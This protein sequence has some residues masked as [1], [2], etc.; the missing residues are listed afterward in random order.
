MAVIEHAPWQRPRPTLAWTAAGVVLVAVVALYLALWGTRYGL[1]LHVYRSGVDRWVDGTS[2]YGRLYTRYGLPYTY[3][4]FSLV[5]FAPLALAPFAIT[6]ALWWLVSLGALVLAVAVAAR[7]AG[8]RPGSAAWCAA[9]GWAVVSVLVVEPARSTFDYGQVNAVLLCLVT[10]DLL[11]V[12][13]RRRG[14]LVGLAAA[15]KLTPLVF[16]LVPLLEGDRR[17][18][19]RGAGAFAALTGATWALWPAM[20]THYWAH[21]V[22]SPDQIGPVGAAANQSLYG[23]VHRA[24]FPAGGVPALW[25]GA[26]LVVLAMTCVAARG[27]LERGDRLGALLAV[28][29]CGLLV[30][31]VSWSHHWIWVVLVPVVVARRAPVAPAASVRLGLV[32]LLALAVAAPYWWFSS[33]VLADVL[34]DVLPLWALAVLALWC[35]S[36]LAARTGRA[37]AAPAHAP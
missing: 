29:L 31:P 9:L 4:P 28:A 14:W 33:G 32:G 6:Q 21:Q 15:I 24:P 16:L 18:A 8:L 19:A 37:V 3:P 17:S 23:I 25:A 20:S 27:A 11:A 2:P 35:A 1:D 7:A 12:P 13:A 26:G 22:G 10:V 36:A 5:A 34:V 30:S